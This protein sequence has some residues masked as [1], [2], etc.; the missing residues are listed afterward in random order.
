MVNRENWKLTKSYLEYRSGRVSDKTIARDRSGLR[1]MLEWADA[2]SFYNAHQIKPLF[3]VY[4]GN[5][6]NLI[7]YQSQFRIGIVARSF[8]DWLRRAEPKKSARLSALFLES[9]TPRRRTD[10]AGKLDPYTLDEIITLCTFDGDTSLNT[11]RTQAAIALMFLGGMRAGAVVTIPIECVDLDAREIRQWP[12]RGVDTKRSKRATTYLLNVPGLLDVVQRWDNFVRA[13]MPPTSSWYALIDNQGDGLQDG[14]TTKNRGSKL[15]AYVRNLCTQTGT[16]YRGTHQ[17]RHGH[18]TYA[19][20]HCKD[21]ADYKAVSVNLMHES[22]A[23]TDTVYVNIKAER[24][25]ARIEAL[26]VQDV[27]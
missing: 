26:G 8:F 4:L 25:K 22:I 9:L 10:M 21:M 18:A 20:E 27:S 13:G 12:E 1:H 16:R 19:L 6:S 15:A 2:T 17:I 24:I 14:P 23:T 7:E 11:Q 3:P 5:Q